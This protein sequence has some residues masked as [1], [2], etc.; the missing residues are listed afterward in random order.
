MGAITD[1]LKGKAKEIEGKLTGDR[2]RT[3][4][5]KVEGAKGDVEAA[6]QR[7]SDRVRGAAHRAKARVKSS[8]AK[9]R[10]K[11]RRRTR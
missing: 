7:A 8:A 9:A 2:V 6:A 11:T 5:G 3:G 1:K 4:Q 10:A